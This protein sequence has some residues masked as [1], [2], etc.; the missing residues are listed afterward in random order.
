M[1]SAVRQALVPL[2]HVYAEL[3]AFPLASEAAFHAAVTRLDPPAARDGPDLV[4]QGFER[5]VFRGLPA[6][7][8]D[9]IACLRDRVWFDHADATGSSMHAYLRRHA[10]GLL[11]QSGAWAEPRPTADAAAPEAYAPIFGDDEEGMVAARRRWRWVSFAMP[12]DLLLAGLPGNPPATRVDTLSPMLRTVLADRGYGETHMHV[13][14]ALTFPDLWASTLYTLA[15]PECRD[16]RFASS[17]AA[18]DHGNG[19]AGWLLRAALA[20]CVIATFLAHGQ[21]RWGTLATYV[22]GE[23]AVR[24]RE[25]YGID[26]A[27]AVLT[28]LAELSTGRRRRPSPEWHDLWRAYRDLF[29]AFARDAPN[30]E[31]IGRIDP[32]G[33]V[34]GWRDGDAELPEMR[35]LRRGLRRLETADDHDPGLERLFWQCVR[36]RCLFYRHVTQRPMTPGLHWFLRF[37]GRIKAGRG[38]FDCDSGRMAAS[39]FQLHCGGAGLRSMELRTTPAATW[40]EQADFLRVLHGGLPAGDAEFGVV[41]HF[42]K[43]RGDQTAGGFPA[44]HGAATH[45]DPGRN[46]TGYRYA[47]FYRV[48]AGQARAWVE[49][50]EH[51]PAAVRFVRGVDVCN[52]ER[53]IPNWVLTGPYRQ[54]AEA[55]AAASAR[56][57][58]GTPPPRRTVHVGEDFVHLLSGL[59]LVAEAVRFFEL[60]AGDRLG[61]ALALGVD[62]LEWTA[63]SGRVAVRREERLFDLA[64]EWR[65]CT[66]R[67]AAGVNRLPYVES[68][69]RRL[70]GEIFGDALPSYD[71]APGDIDR[72]VTDLNWTDRLLAVGFPDGVWERDKSCG[73]RRD[74]ILLAYLRS[75]AT[76]RAGQATEWVVTRDEGPVLASLQAEMRREVGRR[77]VV[78]EA[79][80]S[81][82]LL[83]GE[84]GDLRRHPFWRLAGAPGRPTDAPPVTVCLGSDDPIT[85]CTDLRQEYQLVYDA[86]IAA[87][88]STEE[89]LHWIDRVRADGLTAR[90]TLPASPRGRRARQSAG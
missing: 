69:L 23:V 25:R 84:F 45:A 58:D 90:F 1:T 78:V 61:H 10:A 63:R 75:A 35:W 34:L 57:R 32:A 44:A 48:R 30:L 15:Q 79:N 18:F 4:W 55:G 13:G 56:L 50:L 3:L 60:R 47:D 64:W 41:L 62:P 43:E 71:L 8:V 87:G 29:E 39:A 17:G 67:Q 20:R 31:H 46:P 9:E 40:H 68:E 38:W 16:D 22:H 37:F 86:L 7:S 88:C 19:F 77:G 2:D 74:A 66:R 89:T 24:L 27:R 5:E 65:V 59:R 81:S 53:A 83:I 85:F 72:L 6:V 51:F 82:N 42:T 33:A 73:S 36:V 80:P 14:A 12:P 26:F 70:A 49:F 54:V 11:R 28:G 21:A 76:F 52:D